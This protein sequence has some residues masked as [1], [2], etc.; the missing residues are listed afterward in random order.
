M[1]REK[2]LRASLFWLADGTEQSERVHTHTQKKLKGKV[3]VYAS[4]PGKSLWSTVTPIA[5]QPV[6][7][8]G[9]G[10]KSD[11]KLKRIGQV[12]VWGNLVSF[13]KVPIP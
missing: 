2:A 7:G 11:L 13:S 1:E 8:A 10:F 6:Q 4:G 9:E 12:C 3:L 5:K